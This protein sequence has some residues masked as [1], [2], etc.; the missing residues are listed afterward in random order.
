MDFCYC[1]LYS[2]GVYHPLQLGHRFSKLLTLKPWFAGSWEVLNM[3][4]VG[5]H[6]LELYA[7]ERLPDSKTA[8]I[9]TH[10]AKCARCQGKL[11]DVENF[12]S[13]LDDLASKQALRGKEKRKEE[14]FPV[15]KHGIL[16]ALNPNLHRRVEVE[17]RNLS[18]N[19]IGF[20]INER[21]PV[22]T[23]VQVRFDKKFLL[24]SVRYCV[25]NGEDFYAGIKVQS[26]LER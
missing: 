14:R 11:S 7:F 5:D 22:E 19:G 17:I 10:I 1:C 12:K 18:L 20:R 3:R 25:P 6:D 2:P 13:Q 8:S 21:L 23:T 9:R 15:R 24:G 16:V 4:H 26:T